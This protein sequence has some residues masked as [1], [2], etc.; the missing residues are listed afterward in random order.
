MQNNAARTI[1]VVRVCVCVWVYVPVRVR[2]PVRAGEW[3]A[4]ACACTLCLL[5]MWHTLDV[6]HGLHVTARHNAHT[7]LRLLMHIQPREGCRTRWLMYRHAS[8]RI[9]S[10]LTA[11]AD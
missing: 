2:V 7:A 1:P 8:V 10:V 4:C 6:T 11:N 3:N 9:G 5:G